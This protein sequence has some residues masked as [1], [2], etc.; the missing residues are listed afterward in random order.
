MPGAN[1]VWRSAVS[2]ASKAPKGRSVN[3]STFV[4]VSKDSNG[5]LLGTSAG[6]SQHLQTTGP[7]SS[8]AMPNAKTEARHQ[9]GSTL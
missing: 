1:A 7:G 6:A 9:T 3:R 2:R 8:A 4:H 5:K